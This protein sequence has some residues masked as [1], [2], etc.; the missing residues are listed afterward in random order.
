MPRSHLEGEDS[1]PAVYGHAGTRWGH[2]HWYLLHGG[3]S[4]V[5]ATTPSDASVYLYDRQGP[6]PS[7]KTMH[8]TI[9]GT[10][11][12]PPLAHH[13]MVYAGGKAFVVGGLT[14]DGTVSSSVYAIEAGAFA[15]G[16]VGAWWAG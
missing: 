8:V 12:A 4:G 6:Q 14:Q 10:L 16:P 1:F 13:E 11:A 9:N 15:A 7:M 5:D 3:L 2:T